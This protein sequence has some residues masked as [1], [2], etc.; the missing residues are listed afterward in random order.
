M[1]GQAGFRRPG[2]PQSGFDGIGI[3]V[4]SLNNACALS[5]L[6]FRVRALTSTKRQRVR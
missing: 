3:N 4:G 5:Q 6:R 2:G 1:T